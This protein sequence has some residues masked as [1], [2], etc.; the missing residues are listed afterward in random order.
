MLEI[1]L[2]SYSRINDFLKKK[3]ISHKRLAGAG[4]T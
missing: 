1:I 2:I 4:E 3:K